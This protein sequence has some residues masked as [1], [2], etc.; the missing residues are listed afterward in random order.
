MAAR[1]R[2][3]LAAAVLGLGFVAGAAQAAPVPAGPSEE[4]LKEKALKLNELTSLEAAQARLTELLKDKDTAKRL[5][6]V[7]FKVQKNTKD[8]EPAFKYHAAL[9]LAKI[10]HNTKDYDAAE[11]F[12]DSCADQAT[13]L[14]SG[15]MMLQAYEGLMDVY[16]EQ[17]KFQAVEDVA[18]K[19]LEVDGKEAENARMFIF[20]K[21]V[22]AKAKQGDTDGALRMLEGPLAKSKGYWFFLQ[23][24]GWVQREAGKT[25]D[26]IGTY[27]EVLDKIEGSKDLKEEAKP[28]LKKSIQYIMTGLYVDN[29]DVDKAAK[30]LQQLIKEDPDNP[31][32][33][34]DLGFIWADN[35][36]K[37]DES[38]KL[39]RKALELD[40][41]QRKKLL[42]EGKIDADTAKKDNAAYLDSLG[43]VLFKN[44]KYDEAKK[45]LELATKDDDEGKHIEIWDHLA[46]CLV[47]LG[48]KKEAVDI[49]QKSLKFEDVSKRDAERRK[50]V[51]EKMKKVK[52]DLK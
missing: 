14:Q 10:A 11:A 1:L 31:T 52:A 7:A 47:A 13:K 22:Q 20:E 39:I 17:K 49:W 5:V 3:L 6:A 36:L 12:Y 27:E 37:M 21:M 19:L 41:V 25:D 42:E 29:K 40:T 24:K 45:Y 15:K 26:A 28:K 18:N 50:K 46:D 2:V 44:K 43:W 48:K 32:F 23:I 4:Q 30:I 34:N 33:Y 35:D 9:V 8:K 38:E 16:W 51:T